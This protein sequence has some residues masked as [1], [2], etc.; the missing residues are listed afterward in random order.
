MRAIV[1]RRVRAHGR[2]QGVFF[3]DSS[4]RG[5]PA[6]RGG[7]GEELRPTAP[8]RPCSRA[9]PTRSTRWS[10]SCA[11]GPGTRRASGSTSRRGARGPARLR[12]RAEPFRRVG[13]RTVRRRSPWKP[14]PPASAPRP[15]PRRRRARRAPR[16]R[17]RRAPSRSCAR[18][19]RRARTRRRWSTRSRSAPA[20]S[21]ASRPAPDAEF[22]RDGVREGLARGRGARSPTRP[23]GRRVLR[24]AASTRSSGRRTATS[25]RR[26][27]RLFGDESSRRRPAPAAR[28]DGRGTRACAR[29]CSSSS[30]PPTAPTRSP[31]SRP[32][33]CAR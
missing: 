11:T 24:Q 15:R 16:R 1:R 19:R 23:D 26:S 29:T 33:R 13:A 30:P 6:R 17:R 5:R 22:V 25:P 12:R 2:V 32:R 8:S 10:S 9:S 21:T 27:T 18:A 3:R 20:C 7:L 4:A 28:G 31:T 14:P